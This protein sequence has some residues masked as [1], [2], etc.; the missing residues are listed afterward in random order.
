MLVLMLTMLTRSSEIPLRLKRNRLRYFFIITLF[1]ACSL[2]HYVL[3]VRDHIRA[4]ESPQRQHN[5]A[6]VRDA[7]PPPTV[8]CTTEH[9]RKLEEMPQLQSTLSLT[10]ESGCGDSDPWLENFFLNNN[11]PASQEKKTFLVIGCNKAVDSIGTARVMSRNARSFDKKVWY[12]TMR[13]V[14]GLG[15]ERFRSPCAKQKQQT[16]FEEGRFLRQA[17]VTGMS[18]LLLEVHCVEALPQNFDLIHKTLNRLPLFSPEFQVHQYVVSNTTGTLRFPIEG[19]PGDEALGTDSCEQQSYNGSC[20]EVPAL[21]LDDFVER[22]VTKNVDIDVLKIDVEGHD[23]NVLLGGAVTL[24]KTRYLEFEYSSRDP[25]AS[26]RLEDAVEYLDLKGFTCYFM[27]KTSRLFKLTKCFLP[28]KYERYPWSNVTC[29]QR[30][31]EQWAAHLEQL[32]I[33]T[34]R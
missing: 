14:S 32:F 13:N 33:E 5:V 29:V 12:D 26:Q 31:Q 22:H 25:W 21:S 28:E 27:G 30:S 11:S 2:S 3:E 10:L 18:E 9:L 1:C 24:Q 17:N 7:A 8:P 16:R 15:W 6:P 34:I 20:A 4:I 19:V 23:F